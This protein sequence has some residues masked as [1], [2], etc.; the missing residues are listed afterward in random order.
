MTIG[1]QLCP[2]RLMLLVE[3]SLVRRVVG[4]AEVKLTHRVHGNS[5]NVS[6]RDFE[7]GNHQPHPRGAEHGLLGTPDRV[8]HGH[9]VRGMFDWQVC[10]LIDLHARN[11]QSVAGGQRTN[12]EERD[13]DVVLPQHSAWDLPFDDSREDGWHDPTLGRSSVAALR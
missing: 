13:T 6:V 8:G 1:Q 9:D 10:P 12:I 4:V 2:K 11:H 7:T 3:R 5:M